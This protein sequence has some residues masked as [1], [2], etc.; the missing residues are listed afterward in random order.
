MDCDHAQVGR[1]DQLRLHVK[2]QAVP[3]K[4][5]AAAPGVEEAL[6]D[7][8]NHRRAVG[9]VHHAVVVEVDAPPFM[10]DVNVGRGDVPLE[11]AVFQLQHAACVNPP[12]A[13]QVVGAGQV[14]VIAGVVR[15]VE[16][17]APQGEGTRSGTRNRQGPLMFRRI[18]GSAPGESAVMI[19]LSKSRRACM[20][21]KSLRLRSGACTTPR[22]AARPPEW[23]S[24]CARAHARKSR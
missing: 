11:A 2:V 18:R 10:I 13:G 14:D 17:V 12:G 19:A 23:A 15:E 9:G 5:D 3:R 7:F 21:A 20:A 16:V 24:R 4:R 8:G 6:V 1:R 22:S